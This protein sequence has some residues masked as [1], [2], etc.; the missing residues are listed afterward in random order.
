MEKA[1]SISEFEYSNNVQTPKSCVSSIFSS[2][3]NLSLGLGGTN[4]KRKESTISQY[5]TSNKET[6]THSPAISNRILAY[7]RNKYKVS[8]HVEFKAICI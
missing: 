4:E 7:P 3:V 1:K 8:R 5:P 2:I 6:A